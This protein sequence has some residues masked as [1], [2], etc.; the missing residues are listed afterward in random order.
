MALRWLLLGLFLCTACAQEEAGRS[1]EAPPSTPA[2][3][4]AGP[5]RPAEAPVSA[6]DPAQPAA[7]PASEAAA[8]A[9]DLTQ[10]VDSAALRACQ[11]R[12]ADESGKDASLQAYLARLSRLVEARDARGLLALV[13][14]NTVS[15]YGGGE[16]GRHDFARTWELHR[17]SASPI[18]P[19]LR[20]ILALGGVFTSSDEGREF[21]LPYAQDADRIE[22]DTLDFDPYHT[23]VC[24][25]PAT[26]AHLRP[27]TKSAVR[28]RLPYSVVTIDEAQDA[29]KTWGQLYCPNQPNSSCA[30]WVRVSDMQVHPLGYV[31]TTDL[32][33]S[34]DYKLIL[35]P[36]A[37]GRWRIAAY[38]PFD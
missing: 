22:C 20:R 1:A 15:S 25:L 10:P 28:A 26:E 5:T 2:A 9:Y 18:W 17:G 13:D 35:Q 6:A 37:P 38:A 33:F 36:K 3:A 23:A 21:R 24:L 30:A 27:D 34:V 11:L 7:A 14:T 31:R 16:T 4:D 12:P 32:I 29:G 19:K 8:T